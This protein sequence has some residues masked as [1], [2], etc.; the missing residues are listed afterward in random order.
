VSPDAPVRVA[1]PAH[2][3]RSPVSDSEEFRLG[4]D[5]AGSGIEFI[6]NLDERRF[7]N[8]DVFQDA[9]PLGNTIIGFP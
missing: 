8:P 6:L 2:P 1:A 7:P 9:L 3:G 5:F 4:G